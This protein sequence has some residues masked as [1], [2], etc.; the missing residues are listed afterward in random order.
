MEQTSASPAGSVSVR[1]WGV[2]GSVPT[3][4]AATHRYGGNT[5]SVEVQAG[6][7]RFIFDAGTGLRVVGNEMSARGTPDRIHIFL[8]HFHWDH[9]QGFP[10]FRPLYDP[11]TE[12]RIVGPEQEDRDIQT[13]FARQMGPIFFPV[14]FEAVAARTSF[15]HL[16]E[17][18]WEED[19][20]RIHGT[21]VRHPSFTVGYRIEVGGAVICYVPDN[22]LEGGTYA[23][24]RS[25]WSD[26][27]RDFVRGADL[28]IHD[29]MYTDD[30]YR[31]RLGWGHSTYG[32]AL[33]LATEA[34]VKRLLFFHHSPDRTDDELDRIVEHFQE[35]S[36]RVGGPRVDGAKEGVD[37]TV[38]EG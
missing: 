8:T 10:F 27:F 6:Q 24:D 30:E 18:T 35:R 11:G 38:W 2:R 33:E 19:G 21:R 17:G 5:S 14:P 12:L 13:L 25:D 26:R 22:E 34:G 4:G 23:V 36:A 32:Q 1:C 3:P 28:L 9:I 31:G 16:N 37:L 7:R 29:A 15:R 20:V